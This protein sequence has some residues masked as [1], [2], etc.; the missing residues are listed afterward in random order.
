M[1]TWAT[2]S[3]TPQI[4]AGW[5]DDPDLFARTYP[6]DLRP[7][8]P[9]IIRTWRFSTVSRAQLEHGGLPWAHA[10]IN[11]WTLDP[12]RKKMSKSKGTGLGPMPLAEQFG[13]DGLRYWACR[14]APGTDTSSDTTQMK[15]GRRLA[16]KVLNASKFVLGL[17][18]ETPAAADITEALDRAMLAQLAAVAEEATESFAG[19]SYHRALGRP[20]EFFWRFWDAILGSGEARACGGRGPRRTAPVARDGASPALL[21]SCG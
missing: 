16:V 18:S 4:A 15:V 19:Y 13:A 3:L 17:G 8:G 2:S 9:E 7:Q 11:G 14:A 12:D 10:Q 5:V 6:M 21:G 1:D 20:E